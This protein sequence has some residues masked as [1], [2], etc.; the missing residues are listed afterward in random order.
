LVPRGRISKGKLQDLQIR[1][2]ILRLFD[3]FPSL[4]PRHA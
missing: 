1:G 3:S 2:I 4:D